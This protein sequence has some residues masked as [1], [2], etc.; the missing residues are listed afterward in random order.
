M[1]TCSRSNTIV[2]HYEFISG[3]TVNRCGFTLIRA[4]N[5]KGYSAKTLTIEDEVINEASSPYMVYGCMIL[6]IEA[7]SPMLI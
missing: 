1:Q 3:S 4:V 5:V 7:I 2:I 6:Q